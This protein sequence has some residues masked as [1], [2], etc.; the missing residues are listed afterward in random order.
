MRQTVFLAGATGYI[1]SNF[2]QQFND[3]LSIVPIV[4]REPFG[5]PPNLRIL[6]FTDL[7][8]SN[9]PSSVMEQSVLIHLVGCGREKRLNAIYEG[10]VAI[11]EYLVQACKRLGIGRIIY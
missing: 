3:K 11:T 8:S 6:R 1:G 10:N 2:V 5:F 7:N 9:V 4:R